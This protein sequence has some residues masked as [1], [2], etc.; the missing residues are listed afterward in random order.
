[1]QPFKLTIY[2]LCAEMLALTSLTC[3][4][5]QTTNVCLY[6]ICMCISRT[7]LQLIIKQNK[8]NRLLLS[9]WC[10]PLSTITGVNFA[11][12]K[13]EICWWHGRRRR[14]VL[15][16]D[17]CKLFLKK[18]CH[19]DVDGIWRVKVR[20][21]AILFFIVINIMILLALE[22]QCRRSSSLSVR[23]FHGWSLFCGWWENIRPG[24]CLR[25]VP[26]LSFSTLTQFVEWQKRHLAHKNLCHLV[27]PV[28][29]FLNYWGR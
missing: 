12:F 11:I 25:S 21:A 26:R 24:H 5:Q 3:S 10:W 14:G 8:I 18:H 22:S 7:C 16:R 23:R 2:S 1:M 17:R 20:L 29:P 19:C 15:T 28:V 27:S 9:V 6:C 4:L 13:N